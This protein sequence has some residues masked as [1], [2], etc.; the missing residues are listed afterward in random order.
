MGAGGP[1]HRYLSA[2][3]D[4]YPLSI[5]GVGLSLGAD[6]PLNKDH[7]RRVKQL[8]AHYE[9]A[10]F[11]EHLALSTHDAGFLNDLLPVPYTKAAL[12]RVVSHIDEV[13]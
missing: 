1:P 8:V 2:I 5:H 12:A 9:P 4:A 13:Q 10:V 7:L 6:R 11:S 3:R